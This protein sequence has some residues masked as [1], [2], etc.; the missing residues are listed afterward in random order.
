MNEADTRAELIE[1]QLRASGWGEN[2][3]RILREQSAQ[4][5]VG[6]VQAGGT[7]TKPLWVDFILEYKNRK[8]AAI[9]AKS[10]AQRLEAVCRGKLTALDELK[11]HCFTGR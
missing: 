3:S 2:G 4:I 8:L 1:P 10:G 7:R 6:K 11:S 9:E 5:T